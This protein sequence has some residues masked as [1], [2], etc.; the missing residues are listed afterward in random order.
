[1]DIVQ[2]TETINAPIAEVWA[3]ISGFG[4][5]KSWMTVVKSC[6]LEGWGIGS[7]RTVDSGGTTGG[8]AV[9]VASVIALAAA[10]MAVT[11]L[12]LGLLPRLERRAGQAPPPAAE[13]VSSS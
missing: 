5:N 12:R 13:T 8:R 2:L 1:M 3:V 11:L 7:V 4:N 9:A 6:S 10:I